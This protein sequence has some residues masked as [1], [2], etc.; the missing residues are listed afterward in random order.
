MESASGFLPLRERLVPGVQIMPTLWPTMSPKLRLIIR[1]GPSPDWSQT[2]GGPMLR[3]K[4]SGE[5]ASTCAWPDSSAR[6]QDALFFCRQHRSVVCGEPQQRGP[7]DFFVLHDRG[8]RVSDVR[9]DDF[10]SVEQDE[11]PR[12][13][14]EPTVDRLE[15]HQPLVDLQT[16]VLQGVDVLLVRVLALR[17]KVKLERGWS[18]RPT[19]QRFLQKLRHLVAQSPVAVENR[20]SAAAVRLVEVDLDENRVLVRFGPPVRVSW[21]SLEIVFGERFVRRVFPGF[22][23]EVI[24]FLRL[25]LDRV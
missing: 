24:R 22:A 11:D 4:L 10:A 19:R 9:T 13:P 3:P 7:V 18:A 17:A 15:A 20:E 6:L 1:P 23:V 8:S 14:A 25:G 5:R 12:A 2:R 21:V 16:D